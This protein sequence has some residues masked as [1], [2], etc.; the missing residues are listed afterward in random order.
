M[1][2]QYYNFS[3]TILEILQS[4]GGSFEGRDRLQR[5]AFMLHSLGNEKFARLR[6]EYDSRG[7][8][9]LE[10]S[11]ALHESI[12]VGFV[13]E[14]RH[15]L[16]GEYRYVYT[17]TNAGKEWLLQNITDCDTCIKHAIDIFGRVPD[18][19]IRLSSIVLYL[20]Q[21]NLHDREHALSEALELNPSLR[22]QSRRAEG[23]IQ[24]FG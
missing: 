5:L 9:S 3:Y 8:Y 18:E 2:Q 10:V 22:D 19:A 21:E 11:D 20:S 23:L 6:F 7:P 13:M 14:T 4:A 12:A 17:L 1:K 24:Q 15:F 16:Q